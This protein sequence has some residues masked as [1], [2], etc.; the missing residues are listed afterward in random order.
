MKATNLKDAFKNLDPRRALTGPG[1]LKE[2]F[3]ERPDSPLNSLGL[4]LKSSKHH[5][6]ILFTGHMG[7][8]K[9]T[10][11]AKLAQTIE[12]EFF[13]IQCS[14]ETHMNIFD[15]SH[16]DVILS[17]GLELLKKCEEQKLEVSDSVLTTFLDFARDITIEVEDGEKIGKEG[18]LEGGLNLGVFTTKLSKRLKT[19]DQTR[20]TIR[21]ALSHRLQ[22]LFD[23]IE[24]LSKEVEKITGKRILAIVENLDK[25][26][27]KR[28]KELFY[29]YGSNLVNPFPSI[30]Y[31]FPIELRFDSAYNQIR[32]YYSH[33]EELP[34]I[35]IRQYNREYDPEGLSQ[36]GADYYQ[37][38][39]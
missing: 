33:V 16:A 6:K 19:E 15:L 25:I 11:L 26:D 20:I 3:V 9:S 18:G 29:K 7:S 32:G 31:T 34:N 36:F 28:A 22:D 21:K 38:T 37:E 30:V 23:N 14:A 5:Q 1:E 13:I 12:D 27:V 4:I 8:G 24:F 39:G 35:K 2:Y 17:I 10:E